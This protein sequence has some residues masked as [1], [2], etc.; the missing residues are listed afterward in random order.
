[1]AEEP[2]KR[3]LDAEARAEQ[4]IARA[5]EE[6]RSIV[7]QARAEV[8]A[9]EARHAERVK[10]IQAAYLAQAEQRARQSITELRRRHQERAAALRAAAAAMEQRALDAALQLI[11]ATGGGR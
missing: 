5:D 11:T 3:L 8:Q 6:R 2:L 7:E 10:E 1:M 4:V 9:Q